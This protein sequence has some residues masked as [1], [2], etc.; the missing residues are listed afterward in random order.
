[1][2]YAIVHGLLLGLYAAVVL[3]AT[4]L[5]KITSPVAVAGATLA[6]AA[7]FGDMCVNCICAALRPSARRTNHSRH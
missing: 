4:H 6:A 5:I 7:L 1:V 3:L 2:S